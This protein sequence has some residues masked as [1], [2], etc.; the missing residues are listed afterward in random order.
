MDTTFENFANQIL[1]HLAIPREQAG[2]A[3]TLKERCAKVDDGAITV[4]GLRRYFRWYKTHV[5]GAPEP[6]HLL[7]YAIKANS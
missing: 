2:H 1:D 4:E 7:L 3:L 6:K 5:K